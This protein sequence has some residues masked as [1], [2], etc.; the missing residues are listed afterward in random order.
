MNMIPIDEA[1][2]LFEN[3]HRLAMNSKNHPRYMPLTRYLDTTILDLKA[4]NRPKPSIWSR[5]WDRI[6]RDPDAPSF[7]RRN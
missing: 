7:F 1:I 5:L 6:G 2:I 3:A 4:R